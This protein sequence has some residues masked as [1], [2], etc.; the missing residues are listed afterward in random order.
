MLTNLVVLV[1]INRL[2]Q[3]FF[4]TDCIGE[5][6]LLTARCADHQLILQE[7][8]LPPSKVWV[9]DI[10]L[11]ND[12]EGHFIKRENT[13]PT[14]TIKKKQFKFYN[15][16]TLF[17]ILEVFVIYFHFVYL[18]VFQLGRM[19]DICNFDHCLNTSSFESWRTYVLS[20]KVYFYELKH[21]CH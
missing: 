20:F 18:L 10:V 13:V 16:H 21:F 11:F 12:A 1:L 14:K 5:L 15:T 2:S 17:G 6:I 19:L 4:L 9:P 3:V 8:R 7:V